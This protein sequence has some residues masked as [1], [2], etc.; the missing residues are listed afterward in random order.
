N[1]ASFYTPQLRATGSRY[2]AHGWIRLREEVLMKLLSVLAW[3]LVVT[4]IGVIGLALAVE[5]YRWIM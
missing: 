1:S 3:L 5:V 2:V 4:V